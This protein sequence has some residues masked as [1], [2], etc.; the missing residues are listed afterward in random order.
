MDKHI[1]A[2]DLADFYS[3]L[4]GG[5]EDRQIKAALNEVMSEMS[6]FE[7]WELGQKVGSALYS[8]RTK[9]RELVG[10][11]IDFDLLAL[12]QKAIATPCWGEW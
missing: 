9:V 8:R 3:A 6:P 11:V 2:E 7:A 4:L 12:R 10:P 5:D 1:D